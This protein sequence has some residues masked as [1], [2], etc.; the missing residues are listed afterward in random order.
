MACGSGADPRVHADE[1]ADETRGKRV[2]EVVDEVGVFA[3]RGIAGGS[4]FELWLLG[5][6]CGELLRRLDR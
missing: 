1:Y 2:G 5:R 6:G 3:G 4:T